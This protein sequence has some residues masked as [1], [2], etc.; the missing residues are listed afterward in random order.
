MIFVIL[1]LL[2]L[3]LLACAFMLGF[4]TAELK[5]C[6]IMGAAIRLVGRTIDRDMNTALPPEEF[7]KGY[8]R[9]QG[10]N[11]IIGFIQSFY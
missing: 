11:E 9:V 10:M 6:E 4:Y 8:R 1:P 3:M 5:N 2:F 7:E